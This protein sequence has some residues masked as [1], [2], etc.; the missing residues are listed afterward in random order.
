MS[1]ALAG[2]ARRGRGWLGQ[3]PLLVACRR[4]CPASLTVPRCG[5]PRL[6]GHNAERGWPGLAAPTIGLRAGAQPLNRSSSMLSARLVEL[7]CDIEPIVAQQ[8]A[9]HTSAVYGTSLARSRHCSA[10]EGS[11]SASSAIPFSTKIEAEDYRTKPSG[12]ARRAL[13]PG[14]TGEHVGRRTGGWASVKRDC[15]CASRAPGARCYAAEAAALRSKFDQ[16]VARAGR[17]VKNPRFKNGRLRTVEL[18]VLQRLGIVASIIWAVSAGIYTHNADIERAESF[19]KF[20][21]K[22]CA[23]TKSLARD[24][25]IFQ[26]ANKSAR[27]I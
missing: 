18:T 24:A 4:Y 26:A 9:F 14:R 27:R 22:V 16:G 11:R 2:A 25:A 15:G 3:R 17:A 12:E 13:S 8:S 1:P 21:Y 23:D 5:S 10:A 7:L 19:A 20:A 6:S